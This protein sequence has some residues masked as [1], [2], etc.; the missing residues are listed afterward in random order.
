[1][2]VPS[3]SPISSSHGEAGAAD[4]DV[5]PVP[6]DAQVR[7]LLA[8]DEDDR[9]AVAQARAVVGHHRAGRRGHAGGALSDADAPPPRA[10]ARLHR[11]HH[12]AERAQLAVRRHAAA[13]RTRA[14]P[15]RLGGSAKAAARVRR[16]SF[17]KASFVPGLAVSRR[18]S[19]SLYTS[20]VAPV[21]FGHSSTM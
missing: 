2:M 18:L 5:P 19:V 9:L 17:T 6:Q 12:A 14:A 20:C 15:A 8:V 16:N 11:A 10:A 13:A 1:M 3:G 7:A 21:A 4:G